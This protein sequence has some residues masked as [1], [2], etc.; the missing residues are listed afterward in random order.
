MSF[1][2]A[3][4][5]RRSTTARRL[6]DSQ[7]QVPG[8]RPCI[9]GDRTS[10]N[11]VSR[12][13]RGV[14]LFGII[15]AMFPLAMPFTPLASEEYRYTTATL[16]SHIPMMAM[17]LAMAAAI[18]RGKYLHAIEHVLWVSC[19]SF[20]LFWDVVALTSTYDYNYVG[21]GKNTLLIIACFMIALTLPGKK[22]LVLIAGLY[23]VHMSLL[24]TR[25]LRE[26]WHDLHLYHLVDSTLTTMVLLLIVSVPLY[27]AAVSASDS[28]REVMRIEATTDHLTGLPNRRWL[29]DRLNSSPPPYIALLDLD[30][31]KQINDTHGHAM[32]DEVLKTTASTLA[33]AFSMVGHVGRWGGEEFLVLVDASSLE[34]ATAA[35]IRAQERVAEQPGELDVTFSVGLTA[36]DSDSDAALSRADKL[37]YRIKRSGKN[38]VATVDGSSYRAEGTERYEQAT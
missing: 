15:L 4:N 6:P 26:S 5:R 3:L 34:E 10:S 21:A 22:S 16:V 35:M 37:M 25:L 2:N 33:D 17:G 14:Y 36:V 28:A 8:K 13:K 1:R 7:Q 23:V 29:M 18:I 11:I 9:L 19:V 32:G 20:T 38:G 24:W 27:Q 30:N 31:F 12:G